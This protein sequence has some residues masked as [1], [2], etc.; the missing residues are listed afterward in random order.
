MS[1]YSRREFL[2]T[3]GSGMLASVVGLTAASELNLLGNVFGKEIDRLDFGGLEP[4]VSLIQDT[5]ADDLMPKLMA[6]LDKGTELRALIAAGSLANART[7]GG[8]DYV[9]YHCFMALVPALA[10]S[11]RLSGHKAALPVFKVLHR[12]ARRIQQKGGSRREV[13]RPVE[14]AGPS[15]IPPR[16]QL[17]EAGR[18]GEF[19]SAEATLARVAARSPEAA[20][21]SLQPL[22][23][24]N[25][26]VHQ[27]VLAYRSWDMMRLTGEENAH[28]LRRQVLR[29]CIHRD[30]SR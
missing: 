3:V 23:R 11:Q 24:D 12:N 25:I 8:Q 16:S 17:L 26:D 19:D 20:F 15:S 5:A 9:G 7:F 21:A 6:E 29:H 4:L 10:M 22:V 14:P 18:G 28:V 1:A 27:V 2:G 13:L 30:E